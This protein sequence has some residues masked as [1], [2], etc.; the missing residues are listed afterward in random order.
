MKDNIEDLIPILK[1]EIETKGIEHLFN[2]VDYIAV[3]HSNSDINGIGVFTPMD[4]E[5]DQ[6]I[7]VSHVFYKGFWYMTTHGNYNH[8]EN[9]NCIVEPDNN[10]LVMKAIRDIEHGEELTVDY[11]KQPFLEQPGEDW[12]K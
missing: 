11:R 12:V 1:K 4:L 6:F 2:K 5:D 8:S 10:V 3:Y 9:P 7:G